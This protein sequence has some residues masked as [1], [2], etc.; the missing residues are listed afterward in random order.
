MTPDRGP[1]IRDRAPFRLIPSIEHRVGP[2]LETLPG[3]GP[4]LQAPSSTT[5]RRCGP[6]ERREDLLNVLGDRREVLARISDYLVLSEATSLMN[7]KIA[8]WWIVGNHPS[9]K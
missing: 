4:V 9:F 6:F 5:G 7:R 8:R 2:K 1:A 3:I